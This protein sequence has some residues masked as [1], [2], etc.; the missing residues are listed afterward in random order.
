V[1]GRRR[2]GS[3]LDGRGGRCFGRL[4]GLPLLATTLAFAAPV[5]AAGLPPTETV[6]PRTTRAWASAPDSAALRARFERSALGR[7][8]DEPLMQRFYDALEAQRSNIAGDRMGFGI[9]PQE[10]ERITGGESALAAVEGADGT[11]SGLL[12]IDTGGHDDVVPATLEKVFARLTEK[13]ARRLPAPERITAFELPPLAPRAG[14]T[15]EPARPRR[16]AY[17][18]IPGA[19]VVGTSPEIVAETLPAIPSGRDDSLGSL[20]A[21]R[22][23]MERTGA[24][25]PAGTP[26]GRWFVDPLAY[27]AAQQKSRPAP[28]KPSKRKPTDM[29]ELARRNGFDCVRGA[30][31]VVFFGEG[32]ID[33]RHQSLIYAPPTGTGTERYQ[34]AARILEFPNASS[35]VPP[36]WVPGDA[37]NWAGLRWDLPKVFRALEP[38]V[39]DLV[40]EPGVFDDVIS[41]LKEDP[42]GPQI[43]VENDLIR[44]LA[45]TLTVAANHVVPF[46]PD[47]ERMLIALETSDPE[48]VAATIAKSMATEA[49][50]KRVEYGGHVIWETI[51][52]DEGRARRSTRVS[53][54]EGEDD[55]RPRGALGGEPDTA[56]FPNGAVAVAH[57]HVLVASHRDILEKVLDG[58]AP[59]F[60]NE[61]D[62]RESVEELK[63]I[64]PGDAALRTFARTGSMI[65]PTYELLRAGKGPENKSLTGRLVSALIDAREH[66]GAGFGKKPATPRKPRIDGT[67]LPEFSSIAHYFGTAGMTMQTV[68]DGF[69]FAGASL[70]D[71]GAA[72]APAAA[73]ASSA[74]PAEPA[75]PAA[76]AEPPEPAGD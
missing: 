69:L 58:K 66:P 53:T 59:S 22:V 45:G 27:A 13:G 49:N 67:T 46:G 50:T 51:P 5:G 2:I 1:A 71:G 76:A 48:T 68:P 26:S 24:A 73:A 41:S 63:A 3:A 28:K 47:C 75:E 12:L 7:L 20:E 44:H 62:Y 52:D 72:A 38:L 54:A 14:E 40:G 57:G 9:T 39:D 33:L 70:W 25:L 21:F 60:D 43:D 35:I 11:L 18:A 65:Q 61:A 19:L 15:A 34:K 55:D 37:A 29:V 30:G 56:A 31:G 4:L 32:K 42:D 6:L 8:L 10:L 64:L 17:A 23:V 74:E 36:S 16:L